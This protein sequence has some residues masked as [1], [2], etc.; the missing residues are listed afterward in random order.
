[1]KSSSFILILGSL[2]VA[3]F[4]Y[5]WYSSNDSSYEP[6]VTFLSSL[7][8]GLGYYFSS[9][10]EQSKETNPKKIKIKGNHNIVINDSDNNHINIR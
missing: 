7:L 3:F 10:K 1:M 6:W 9:K 2:I 8:T 5:K 4:A